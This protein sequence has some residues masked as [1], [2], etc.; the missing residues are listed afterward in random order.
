MTAI[1]TILN[2][3]K[4]E[5]IQMNLDAEERIEE[6]IQKC[7]DF[8]CPAGGT[9]FG[10][11]GQ[12]E[13]GE[14]QEVYQDHVLLKGDA[15]L[16]S[17]KTV[18]SYNI[19]DGDVLKFVKRSVLKSSAGGTKSPRDRSLGRDESIE[20]AQRWLNENIG[21]E[22]TDLELVSEKE[23]DGCLTLVFKETGDNEYFTVRLEG[24]VVS[25]Y[26]PV[27]AETERG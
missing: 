22:G 13:Q 27:R 20:R 1:V 16:D 14:D 2:A 3:E 19:Q 5:S 6:I 18:I 23:D 8:W 12:D 26:L 25:E 11:G 24:G 10:Y 7:E 4:E 17:E 9:D 21:V 15:V